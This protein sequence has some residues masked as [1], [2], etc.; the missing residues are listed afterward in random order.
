VKELFR[1]T[2][3]KDYVELVGRQTKAF[4]R[5]REIYPLPFLLSVLEASCVGPRRSIAAGHRAFIR[6]SG[7][8]I[9]D[10]SYDTK[11]ASVATVHFF[12]RLFSDLLAGG[13]RAAYRALPAPLREFVDILIDDGS[14]MNVRK[15]LAERLRSTT[16][17]QA[18]LKLMATVS[19]AKG[20]LVDARIGAA[21]H[22]DRR[23]LRSKPVPGA[24]HL[25]DL[26]FYDHQEMARLDDANAFFVLRLKAIA[27]PTLQEV[28]QGSDALASDLGDVLD[29]GATCGA[30]VDV[31]ASFR[32]DDG[33]QRTFRVVSIEV[34]C[35]DRHDKPLGEK[36]R[37]W[38][39]CNLPREVWS[40]ES[41]ATLYRLRYSVIERYFR[42][43]KHLG[44]MDHMDTGRMT[45]IM[46]FLLAT[47]IL[48]T[49]A[50]RLT[51]QLI[52]DL[53]F[54]NVSGERIMSCLVEGWSVMA[55]SLARSNPWQS[56]VWFNTIRM[57]KQQGRHPNPH[58]P[59]R[60]AQVAKIL[61]D[62]F[63][64]Q[65]VEMAS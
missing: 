25:R 15:S 46:T 57:L 35:T 28:F 49:L 33:S 62:E 6:I 19:L 17:G 14:R 8:P 7:R 40:V 1:A 59:Q 10:N 36:V 61:N 54:G 2:F 47:L 42:S 38:F 34:P 29:R 16:E 64:T 48:Q 21:L 20:E 43:G 12:F 65:P 32:L 30:H 18:A 56:M 44:R 45:V 52:Q 22:H 23:L 39:V 53:G 24:L 26:G 50:N 41:I 60:A 3:S 11:L 5:F 51:Q 55:N 31:D 27:K 13:N 9:S 37:L 4:E 58:Q 63:A